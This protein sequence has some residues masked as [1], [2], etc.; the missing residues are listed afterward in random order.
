MYFQ[1]ATYWLEQ[2]ICPKIFLGPY[3]PK[4]QCGTASGKQTKNPRTPAWGIH[5]EE[6][7]VLPSGLRLKSWETSRTAY[8]FVPG[9]ADVLTC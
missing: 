3:L 1:A 4:T 7:R 2:I 5:P 9:A 8:N 6:Q